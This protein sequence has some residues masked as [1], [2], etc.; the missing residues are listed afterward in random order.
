M[1]AAV[2]AAVGE[3]VGAAVGEAV[4]LAMG[5]L[6]G[7]AV[8]A[9]GVLQQTGIPGPYQ[10]VQKRATEAHFPESAQSLLF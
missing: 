9:M 2:G 1:G 5:S 3:A 4:G 6:V 8:G 10:M 7:A